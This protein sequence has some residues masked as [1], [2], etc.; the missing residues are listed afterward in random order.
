MTRTILAIPEPASVADPRPQPIA[1]GPTRIAVIIPYYQ[2]DKGI[3]S[4]AVTSVL[5]QELPSATTLRVIVVDDA[6]PLAAEIDLA[7]LATV[8][9]ITIDLVRQANA[10][11]GGARNR[12]LEMVEQGGGA[13]FVAFLDSDDIW[14]PT[15]LAD[16]LASLQKGYDFYCC[17]NSRDGAFARFSEDVALLSNQGRALAD[18][19]TVLDPEGPVLGFAPH[20]LDDEFVTGYLSHTSTV[21]LRA[22]LICGQRF[23]PELRNASEDRM[24]W[25][26]AVLSG[27]A[28]ALSW[29]CNVSCGKGV[30]IFFAAYDW[31]TPATLERIGCQLL[32][33]QKL[34]RMPVM[35][36]ARAEFAKTRTRKTRRAYSF[37]FL[38]TLFRGRRPP[39]QSFWRL[40]R[41]DPW[42]PLR[43]PVLFV[44]VLFDRGPNARSF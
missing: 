27:A 44:A 12:G 30:N 14:M 16:A 26:T 20:M 7:G 4:R 13:D 25:L 37:L 33:A 5:G 15:H 35:T 31:N 38:R 6:S 41:L 24:F 32:F 2:R 9:G 1:E 36:P 11:P 34:L 3:L 42:L 22:S 17:D 23:D 40:L 39:M 10:G 8:A 18:R 28:V 29:R 43:M 19:A 21:V